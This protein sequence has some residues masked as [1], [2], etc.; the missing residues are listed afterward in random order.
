MLFIE[1]LYTLFLLW[2]KYIQRSCGSFKEIVALY[3]CHHHAVF[4][5]AIVSQI[6]VP[7]FF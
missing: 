1:F 5:Q 3:F 2:Y 6:H 7:N 4:V